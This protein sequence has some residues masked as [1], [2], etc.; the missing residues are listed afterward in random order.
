MHLYKCTVKKKLGQAAWEKNRKMPIC[1]RARAVR[2]GLPADKV[3][4]GTWGWEGLNQ[5]T[6]HAMDTS[7]PINS[8]IKT[9]RTGKAFEDVNED[10]WRW[11]QDRMGQFEWGKSVRISSRPRSVFRTQNQNS[12]ASG[13]NKVLPADIGPCAGLTPIQVRSLRRWWAHLQMKQWS[14]SPWETACGHGQKELRKEVRGWLEKSDLKWF[15]N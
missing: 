13:S 3:W 15:G 11:M 10:V 14:A 1:H 9:L 5:I 2:E 4:A 7:N 6:N 8:F 12:G